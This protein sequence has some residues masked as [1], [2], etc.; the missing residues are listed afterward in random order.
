MFATLLGIF[1][2][3]TSDVAITEVLEL[4]VFVKNLLKAQF[5]DLF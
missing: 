2:I 4:N 3:S 5:R 1:E